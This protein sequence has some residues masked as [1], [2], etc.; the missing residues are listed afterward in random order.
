MY[1][2]PAACVCAGAGAGAGVGAGSGAGDVALPDA[3]PEELAE[4]EHVLPHL[5]RISYH[6]PDV[7]RAMVMWP[8][9]R[10]VTE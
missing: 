1:Y 7:S 2:Y 9:I 6:G 4:D 8:P 10:D 5:S 3:V